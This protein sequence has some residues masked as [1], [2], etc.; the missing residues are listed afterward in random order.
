MKTPRAPIDLVVDDQRDEERATDAALSHD[1]SRPPEPL[2]AAHVLDE[3]VAAAAERAERE[4]EE[5]LGEIRVRPVEP[6]EAAATRR[7]PSRR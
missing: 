7:S 6:T 2:V 4:L 5:A 1:A 3:D